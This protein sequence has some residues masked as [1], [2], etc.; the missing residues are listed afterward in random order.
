MDKTNVAK[1][2]RSEKLVRNF[3]IYPTLILLLFL[4]AYPIVMVVVS[5]FDE[6][7][8]LRPGPHTDV[9]LR[10]YVNILTSDYAW[11]RFIFT[12]KYTVLAVTIQFFLGMF[13][14]Y[15][16]QSKFKGR[17]II[18]T[19]VLIPMMLSPV[20]IGLL[21]KYMFNPEWGIVN[22]FLHDLLG[23]PLISWLSVPEYSIWAIVITDTW[24]WTPFMVLLCSAGFSAVP[25]HLYEAAEVDRASAWFK[26]TRI[27]LPI[28]API[29]LLALLFRTMDTIKRFDLIDTL[30]GGGP[31][32]ATQ[33]V[34]YSLYRTAFK[35]FY[36]GEG[37]AWAFILLVVI[38]GM[39]AILVKLLNYLAKRSS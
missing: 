36:T 17:D 9:G 29:L 25:Q 33:T 26:F 16:L 3:F 14:A 15:L 11:E 20:V 34:A 24:Q 27:T 22:Y 1:H 8:Y 2:L 38:L 31:G 30:T 6:F 37:S 19:I 21:W 35:Y 12:G 10:H 39:S 5:S 7:S 32:D 13:I 4:I 23:F 18:F 28:S